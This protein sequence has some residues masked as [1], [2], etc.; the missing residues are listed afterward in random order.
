VKWLVLFLLTINDAWA[1]TTVRG[2]VKGES[3]YWTNALAIA[4]NQM[5]PSFWQHAA[6]LPATNS[7]L[8]GGLASLP[9][10]IITLYKG[11]DSVSIPVQFLGFEYNMGS[12]TPIVGADYSG[13][14]CTNNSHNGGLVRITGGQ[15]CFL[16]YR[17]DYLITVAPFTFI[18]PVFYIN[19]TDVKSAFST[20]P[21]G[22]YLGQT[23]LT[24]LYNYKHINVESRQYLDHTFGLE[25]HHQPSVINSVTV[26]GNNELT[27]QYDLKQ[28]RV[29]ASSTFKLMAS[30]FFTNGLK[31]NLINHR[32]DYLLQGPNL[33]KIPYSVDCINCQT[34]SL[35]SNGKVVNFTSKVL[36][37][38]TT[39]INFDIEVFFENQ[40]LSLIEVGQY[41]DTITLLV[42]PDI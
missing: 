15:N 19:P 32:T 31:V 8:P 33:T 4:N 37:S 42:E 11:V 17:L 34:K 16:N 25:I 3:F 36:G 20:Q 1:G 18:R 29:S 2:E 22:V 23:K 13:S 27:T 26:T 12:A 21:A 6:N 38:N 7:W 30:G 9:A 10:S 35:I 24:N 41:S 40:D 5:V 14:V 28:Q 39:F